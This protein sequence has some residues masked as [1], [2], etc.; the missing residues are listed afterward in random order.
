M[1][2]TVPLDALTTRTKV[3]SYMGITGTDND[4]V[5]DE[6]ITGVTAFIKSYCGG[7]KFLQA[8]YVEIYD[9]RHGRHK[10]FLNIIPVTGV[11][12]VEYRSGPASNPT[13]VAYNADSYLLYGNGGYIHFFGALPEVPQG[14]RITYFAGY[15]IDFTQEFDTGFHTL[16]ADITLAAN[17]IIATI[18]NTRKSAGITTE[19]TEGQAITYD[20]MAG[21]MSKNAKNILNGYKIYRIAR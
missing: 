8:D 21:A 1:P 20:T 17:E 18:L 19:S 13:W 15:S 5:I 9:S 3:K 10:I 12:S 7:R 14:L 11:T 6:L 2:T 16:P 4:T